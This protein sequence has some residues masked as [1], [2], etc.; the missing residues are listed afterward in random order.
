VERSRRALPNDF[1]I[2]PDQLRTARLVLRRWRVSDAAELEP[3]LTANVEHLGDW[4][5]RRVSEPASVDRLSERL[6]GFSAAFHA[7]REW[8]YAIFTADPQRLLGEV[9]L[10]PRVASARVPF[11]DADRVEI[12][13][14]LRADAT[15]HGYATEAAQAAV[16]IALSLPGISHLTIQCDERNEPS[17]AIPL[18]LGF[19][20]GSTVVVPGASES[21]SPRRLQVWEYR[22]SRS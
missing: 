7:T 20:L 4:I 5:P 3:I 21:G 10:F 13:Y 16:D 1:P 2:I 8:R 22:H 18:R 15:G 6:R 14:W 17:A 12:G 11:A 19:N 9:S